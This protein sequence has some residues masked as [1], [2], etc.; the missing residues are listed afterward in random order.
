[1]SNLTKRLD[2]LEAAI[3]PSPKYALVAYPHGANG[4]VEYLV[5]GKKVTS[6][7]PDAMIIKTM[8][9][10]SLEDL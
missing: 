8:V 1:M 3:N 5:N 4:P 7:P 6:L 2:E 10:V 9:N